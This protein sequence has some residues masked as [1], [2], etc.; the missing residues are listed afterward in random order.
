MALPLFGACFASHADDTFE[1]CTVEPT[2]PIDTGA[3]I[4]HTAGVDAG[5]YAEYNGAGAWHFEWTC[6]TRLSAAGCNFTGSFTVP[7]PAGGVDAT[8]FDCEPED[9]LTTAV[10]GANTV[11]DFDTV[12]STGIDGVDFT[13][14]TGASIEID[15]QVNGIYQ[16]DIVFLPSGGQTTI[17]PCMPLVLAPTTP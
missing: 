6:D 8:C 9:I 3:S 16:N 1:T 17:P 7:T 4:D 11:I 12:T 14:P 13:A 2:L 15:L 10:S 5:Y